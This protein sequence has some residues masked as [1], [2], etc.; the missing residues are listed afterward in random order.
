[1]ISSNDDSSSLYRYNL[2]ACTQCGKAVGASTEL[3]EE[4]EEPFEWLYDE[5]TI[6]TSTTAASTF[7][8]YIS[9]YEPVDDD[10]PMSSTIQGNK[11]F[12]EWLVSTNYKG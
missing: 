3:S 5:F 7:S 4:A 8:R 9:D 12:K 2:W 1:M 11:K 10:V 6:H